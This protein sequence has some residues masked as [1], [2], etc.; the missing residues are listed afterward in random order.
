[1][2]VIASWS[3]EDT[4]IGPVLDALDKLRC[5]G[6]RRATRTAVMTLVVVGHRPEELERTMEGLRELGARHPAR[7]VA[8]ELGDDTHA[9]LGAGLE[10]HAFSAAEGRGSS[11]DVVRLSVSGPVT[12]HLDSLIEPFTLPDLPVVSWFVDALPQADSAVLAASDVAMVDARDFG[13]P[14]CFATVAAISRVRPVIDLSWVRLK[15]WRSTLRSLFDA[16]VLAPFTGH[17]T[18]AV[19]R[20]KAGPR[21]LLAGWLADRL[22]LPL[23]AFHLHEA[24]HAEV[25]L[26]AATDGRTAT[27]G[28]HR[29]G[30]ARLLRATATVDGGPSLSSSVPL[31]PAGPAWGLAEALSRLQRDPLYEAA[32]GAALD[33]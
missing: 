17:V 30:H 13:G 16:P 10:I 1:M 5:Q 33:F 3:A 4:T 31:P 23:S 29:G 7:V 15:P 2:S 14:S 12:R 32:L 19:V 11:F 20:G 25:V 21:H 22:D 28:V 24:D 27:V 26:H 6:D 9:R 8:L 18:S